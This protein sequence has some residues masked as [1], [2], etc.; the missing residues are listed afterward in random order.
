MAM[1]TQQAELRG[2]LEKVSQLSEE[3]G[4]L[5]AEL[6]VAEERLTGAIYAIQ[7]KWGK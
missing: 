2:E 1:T 6:A 4:K 7:Q 5:K 3:V